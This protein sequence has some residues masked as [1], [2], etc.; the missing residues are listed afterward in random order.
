[1]D[2][3]KVIELLEDALDRM[4]ACGE[5]DTR[6]YD[7]V[8][9]AL[10]VLREP[11]PPTTELSKELRKCGVCVH[12][13]CEK[14]VADDLQKHLNLA[15]DELDRQ[16]QEI[17]KL[18]AEKDSSD[19]CLGMVAAA[20]EQVGCRHGH[21]ISNTP[22]MCYDDAI[23]CAIGQRENEIAKLREELREANEWIAGYS[24]TLNGIAQ[25]HQG[26]TDKLARIE[27][28]WREY[29]HPS[30]Q[31]ETPL[32]VLLTLLDEIFQEKD[33][34]MD[35]K[36]VTDNPQNPTPAEIAKTLRNLIPQLLTVQCQLIAAADL[37][38]HQ[39]EQIEAFKKRFVAGEDGPG[40]LA[41]DNAG[42]QVWVTKKS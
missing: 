22:P 14:T 21:D 4:R 33:L 6:T 2:S 36:T 26:L 9:Q 18:K 17:K 30:P 3:K 23:L 31:S 10:H 41:T 24:E 15:A 40:F 35:E 13:A 39:Q 11:E 19:E 8:A 5:E 29:H 28:A 12:L 38:D 27:G 20:L 25:D 42:I 1:M 16:Q 32:L 34:P 7:T 37:I